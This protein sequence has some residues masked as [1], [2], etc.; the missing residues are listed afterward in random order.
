LDKIENTVL[1]QCIL[2]K[3]LNRNL[4][5]LIN[6]CDSVIDIS[7][8]EVKFMKTRN[9]Y[10]IQSYASINDFGKRVAGAMQNDEHLISIQISSHVKNLARTLK[11]FGYEKYDKDVIGRALSIIT[12]ESMENAPKEVQDQFIEYYKALEEKDSK[13]DNQGIAWLAKQ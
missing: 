3:K 11:K 9:Q 5:T 1:L 4:L 6:S 10:I 2:N 8:Q 12:A 7:K 13:K